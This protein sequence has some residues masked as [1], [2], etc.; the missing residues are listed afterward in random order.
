[1]ERFDR[2]K[3]NFP[4][5]PQDENISAIAVRVCHELDLKGFVN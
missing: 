1:M 5:A 2:E 4:E 3:K